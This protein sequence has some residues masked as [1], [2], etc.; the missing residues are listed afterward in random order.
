M[1]AAGALTVGDISRMGDYEG[2]PSVQGSRN[3]DVWKLPAW[4]QQST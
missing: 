1:D 2:L 4:T 3:E